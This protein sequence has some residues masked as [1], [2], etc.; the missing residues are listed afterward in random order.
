MRP[1]QSAERTEAPAEPAASEPPVR[2]RLKL[3][4]TTGDEALFEGPTQPS[5]A[6][7]FDGE[8]WTWKKLLAEVD[9]G[10]PPAPAPVD[11]DTPRLLSQILALGIDPTALLPRTRLEEIAAVLKDG[12]Q[13]AARDVVRRLAPAAMRR[14]S[15]RVL[16]DTAVRTQASH[17]LKRFEI[18]IDEAAAE[19]GDEGLI[20]LIASDQGRAFLLLDAALGEFG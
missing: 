9:D 10:T 19:H 12:D 18:E 5:G 13:G 11:T 8:D 17:F 16:T 6:D 4:P 7:D 15:R 1:S 2:P 3:T 14:L 20:E